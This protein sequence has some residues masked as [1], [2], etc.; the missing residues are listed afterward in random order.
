MRGLILQSILFSSAHAE[1]VDKASTELCQRYINCC[2]DP[3][4]CSEGEDGLL[5]MEQMR[6]NCQKTCKVCDGP[7]SAGLYAGILPDAK[8]G[9]KKQE[10]VRDEALEEQAST[11]TTPPAPVQRPSTSTARPIDAGIASVKDDPSPGIERVGHI[12]QNA[13]PAITNDH[14]AEDEFL[15]I[16]SLYIFSS[17]KL[18]LG[19]V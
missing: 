14:T 11:T 12:P 4:E 3:R 13:A 8:I 15:Y 16:N 17:G 18:I 19:C 1:C 9:Q 7:S 5:T 2:T 6:K 10:V